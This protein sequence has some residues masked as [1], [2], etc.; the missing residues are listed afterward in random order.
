MIIDVCDRLVDEDSVEVDEVLVE[1]EEIDVELCDIDDTSFVFSTAFS[2]TLL[3]SVDEGVETVVD[4]SEFL[5]NRTKRRIINVTPA[6]VKYGI[7][8][9][10]FNSIGLSG[11]ISTS[12][13]FS[14]KPNIPAFPFSIIL[15]F[16]SF[17]LRLSSY[18]PF[19]IAS[20]TFFPL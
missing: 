4:L 18:K 11:V 17:F 5:P 8:F 2:T 19:S 14:K 13:S 20:S 1:L 15:I 16:T 10:N 3:V 12:A 6:P 7:N 9:L